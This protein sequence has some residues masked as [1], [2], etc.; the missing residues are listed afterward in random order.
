MFLSIEEVAAVLGISVSWVRKRI[1]AGDT[2]LSRH[3]KCSH[4]RRAGRQ[5][6]VSPIRIDSYDLA[7]YIL[8]NTRPNGWVRAPQKAT[9]EQIDR[10]VAQIWHWMEWHRTARSSL[11]S[12]GQ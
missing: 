7:E 3:L 10:R 5:R 9:P 12:D 8:T 1:E 11:P 2:L 4:V 6:D